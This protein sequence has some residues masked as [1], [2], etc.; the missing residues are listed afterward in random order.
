MRWPPPS[1]PMHKVRRNGL[2]GGCAGL[3]LA[4]IGWAI[5]PASFYRAYLHSWLLWLDVSLGAMGL[6]MVIHLVGGMWGLAIRRLA[7][8]A[9]MVLPLMALLFLPIIVGVS[10]GLPFPWADPAQWQHDPVLTMRRALFNEPLFLLRAVLYGALWIWLAWKLWT[11]SRQADTAADGAALNRLY[12]LSGIGLVLYVLTMGLFA[13]TDWVL[14]VEPHYYST[15]FGLM[16]VAGQGVS[17]LCVVIAALCLLSSRILPRHTISAEQWNDLGTILLTAAM[18]WCYLVVCQFIVNWMADTQ[19]GNRWYL[20]RMNNGFWWIS[21]IIVLLHLFMP[22]VLLLIRWV[23]QTPLLML[24]ICVVLLAT[25]ALE[26]FMLINPSGENPLPHL[27]ERFSWLDV[28]LP[29]AIGGLWIAGFTFV[30]EQAPLQVERGPSA[31]GAA[32]GV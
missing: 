18:L 12:V 28:V 6:V 30:L 32:R 21:V 3:L 19:D 16:I 4:V 11:G 7:E 15:V 29:I 9:A 31:L 2:I 23:K 22:L 1:S 14:S 17:A 13:S 25:R 20:Q 24:W 10:F 5:N 27:W 26:G 8:A